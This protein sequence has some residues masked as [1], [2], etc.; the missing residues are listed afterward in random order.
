MPMA[1]LSSGLGLGWFLITGHVFIRAG[2]SV[3]TA[4]MATRRGQLRRVRACEGMP[5]ATPD[6]ER[7]AAAT[8]IRRAGRCL[9][10]GAGSLRGVG[11]HSAAEL[12]FGKA[13]Y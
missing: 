13:S 8:G 6:V 2:R 1:A 12:A 5:M 10:R 3:H 7:W 11:W 4:V 9:P